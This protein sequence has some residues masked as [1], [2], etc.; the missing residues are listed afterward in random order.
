MPH[1]WAVF[2]HPMMRP[3]MPPYWFR[4][5]SNV[6]H[7]QSGTL[8][9]PVHVTG[10]PNKIHE[11]STNNRPTFLLRRLESAVIAWGSLSRLQ[12]WIKY[13]S[14][15][16]QYLGL[17]WAVQSSSAMDC[18]TVEIP[19]DQDSPKEWRCTAYIWNIAY[20]K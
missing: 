9:C 20:W 18:I 19:R 10:H 17:V 7:F 5:G 8:V 3:I 2:P 6:I 14:G 16:L 4:H 12:W 11:S 15:P 13:K 1:H